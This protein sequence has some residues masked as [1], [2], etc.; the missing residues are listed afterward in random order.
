MKH[1]LLLYFILFSF[2]TSR[3]QNWTQV[4]DTLF[5]QKDIRRGS[6][7]SHKNQL[8]YLDRNSLYTS[9]DNGLHW[10]L[11]NSNLTDFPYLYSYEYDY[12]TTKAYPIVTNG[13]YMFTCRFGKLLKSSDGIKWSQVNNNFFQPEILVSVDDRAYIRSMDSSKPI[14]NEAY[15]YYSDNGDSWIKSDILDSE[16]DFIYSRSLP[17]CFYNSEGR[18]KCADKN[19]KIT[20]VDTERSFYARPV[21]KLNK[22]VFQIYE[23]SF[24][25]NKYYSL[26]R[27]D[28]TAGTWMTISQQLDSL[29]HIGTVDTIIFVRT[30]S[31][32]VYK[33]IR[34]IDAGNSWTTIKTGDEAKNF[35][36]PFN[37]IQ[38]NYRA[39]LNAG[40]G[41]YSGNNLLDGLRISIDNGESW[42][43]NNKDIYS[44][45]FVYASGPNLLAQASS[46]LTI[47]RDNGKNWEEVSF[48]GINKDYVLNNI[49]LLPDK[50]VVAHLGFNDLYYS[51]DNGDS[52]QSFSI[53][54]NHSHIMFN[55]I[56]SVNDKLLL[57][58]NQVINDYTY[59]FDYVSEDNGKTWKDITPNIPQQPYYYTDPSMVFLSNGSVLFG[60]QYDTPSGGSYFRMSY[61]EGKTWKA[62]KG[63][64]LLS[65]EYVFHN[66][67]CDGIDA[68]FSASKLY[69]ENEYKLYK[70]KT[71]GVITEITD[72]DMPLPPYNSFIRIADHI[73]V[74]SSH[75][76][77]KLRDN[78]TTWT[79]VPA[80]GLPYNVLKTSIG[81]N[82]KV[83]ALGTENG[84][85]ISDNEITLAINKS[86]SAY[87]NFQ[88]FPNPAKE[89]FK[90]LNPNPGT[91][92]PKKITILG[93]DGKEVIRFDYNEGE[94][95]DI[96]G[97][98]KGLYIVLLSGNSVTHATKLIVN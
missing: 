11:V 33:I 3:A 87:E 71:S 5:A 24:G 7:I 54:Y 73:Y 61:D 25:L 79:N 20:S 69:T 10:T 40:T 2:Y 55:N 14:P 9:S 46:K 84:I 80:E 27:F 32:N 78:E 64:S 36:M 41:L 30:L 28:L 81:Y 97:L 63:D 86:N 42:S 56:T 26:D 67:Y 96:S 39:M 35:R 88:L 22:F 8:F 94:K 18:F 93:L 90:I 74:S 51:I 31:D 60:I 95:Y 1:I 72:P 49:F 65:N 82:G 21:F 62:Y 58:T 44:R 98:S 16:L 89:V 38:T 76:F 53:P 92:T 17:L 48:P 66:L 43:T 91:D 50:K 34:S 37:T 6:F 85:Y 70:V 75:A 83:L 68:Y 13:D 47:S 15:I 29:V 19:G 4:S 57:R 77:K 59:Y 52:W 23:T 12:Q 45:N